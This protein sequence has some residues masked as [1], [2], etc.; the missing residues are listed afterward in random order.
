MNK[1]IDEKEEREELYKAC[2]KQNWYQRQVD[3]MSKKVIDELPEGADE[4]EYEK[5][6]NKVLNKG[7][8]IGLVIGV[9]FVIVCAFLLRAKNIFG[10]FDR[11]GTI[12]DKLN[13]ITYYMNKYALYDKIDKEEI[14]TKLCDAYLT[15]LEGDEYS[16]YYD[17]DDTADMIQSTIGEYSGIGVLV[18]Q[19]KETNRV[20]VSYI[21]KG[22]TAPD[23]GIEVGDEL[24]KVEDIDVTTLQIDELARKVKGK[25]GTKVKLTIK[26]ED[27]TEKE[28]EV[29][30]AK[31]V[32]E[33]IYTEVVDDNIGYLQIVE[34]EGKSGSQV[35][36]AKNDFL[37][38]DIK[39]LIIDLRGNPGG[40]LNNLLEVSDVFLEN[41]LVTWFENGDGTKEEY[42]TRGGSWD[43]PCVIL[44]DKNTASAAEAFS[45]AMQDYGKAILVGEETFGKGIVQNVY[46]LSDGTLIKFTASKYFTPNGRNFDKNGIKPDVEV[47]IDSNS[48]FDTQYEKAL[49]VLKEEI[50][51]KGE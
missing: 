24:I 22:S 8:T 17:K 14:E 18:T 10:S 3:K 11:T 6:A 2:K 35:A 4:K 12:T 16:C 39:G 50:A 15:I 1:D 36:E 47:K 13:E 20:F 5:A 41:K 25:A 48:K 27:G 26:K 45:G 23:A 37:D 30:R 33:E 32:I 7:F 44:I 21:Y 19:E 31:I 43:I 38:K 46:K 34:F 40:G 9:V 42:Y 51:K 28:V 29:T 49:E